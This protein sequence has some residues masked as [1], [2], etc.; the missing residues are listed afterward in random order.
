V[1]NGCSDYDSDRGFRDQGKCRVVSYEQCQA[2]DDPS[3]RNEA[4]SHIFPK[5]FGAAGH[6]CPDHRTQVFAQSS[7]QDIEH[8]KGQHSRKNGEIQMH[9][10]QG[11]EQNENE[12]LGVALDHSDDLFL[13][14]IIIPH[15]DSHGQGG[16]K[17]LEPEEPGRAVAQEKQCED[18]DNDGPFRFSGDEG[19]DCIEA[20]TEHDAG[21]YASENY[22]Q[23]GEHGIMDAELRNRCDHP[24]D[25]SSDT[26]VYDDE[27]IVEP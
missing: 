1:H 21:N 14:E 22:K 11:K 3:L 17:F 7:Q 10:A 23:W 9:A 12:L 26:E 2:D 18:I 19:V 25:G 20:G 16:E 15:H 27:N 4:P 24:G 6:V 13:H 8:N 5:A